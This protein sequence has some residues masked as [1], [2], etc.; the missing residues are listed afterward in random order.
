[1]VNLASFQDDR[2]HC[3]NWF[4]NAELEG[5]LHGQH[6]TKVKKHNNHDYVT[7]WWGRDVIEPIIEHSP[8]PFFVASPL[9]SFPSLHHTTRN[10]GLGTNPQSHNNASPGKGLG[11]P[12]TWMMS[13]GREVDMGGERGPH[14]KNVLEYTLPVYK[15]SEIEWSSWS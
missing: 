13:G 2:S 4:H 1:M 3:H 14:S 12:I 7:E 11:T 6:S 9:P 10:K 15:T 5:S 8:T